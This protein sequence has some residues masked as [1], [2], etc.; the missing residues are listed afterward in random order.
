MRSIIETNPTRNFHALHQDG[1]FSIRQMA[2]IDDDPSQKTQWLKTF[3]QQSKTEFRAF[4]GQAYALLGVKS[5]YEIPALITQENKRNE[6]SRIAHVRLGKT[7][8]IEGTE[9]EIE[10]KIKS[11]ADMADGVISSLAERSGVLRSVRNRLEMANEVKAIDNPVDLLLIVFDT[12]WSPKARF[13]AARKLYLMK[14]FAS[15]DQRKRETRSSDKFNGFLE[16]LNTYVWSSGKKAETRGSTLLSVHNI[17]DMSCV[18]VKV[19]KNGEDIY[20]ETENDKQIIKRTPVQRRSFQVGKREI[21]AYVMLREQ[22]DPHL[23]ALKLLRKGHENPEIAVEDAVGLI[24]VVDNEHDV[25]L[26]LRHLQD[27]IAE[28]GSLCIL[29]DIKNKLADT[30]HETDGPYS[31]PQLR[32]FQ[33]F[34][35]VGGMRIELVLHT[36]E[37]YVEY[38]YRDGVSHDEYEV[39]RVIETGVADLLF[40]NDFFKID[41]AKQQQRIIQN[42]RRDMRETTGSD[43]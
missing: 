10:T 20:L 21:P 38:L 33:C 17:D 7:Y 37:T 3:N 32:Q 36:N 14:L 40:P 13:E 4:M 34:L 1:I 24:V 42:I 31:S 2:L 25:N 5:A 29:E 22:K 11:F 16:T 43:G 9:R 30:P 41:F 26:F 28:S 39:K 8:G 6:A 27:K 15:I 23:Q 18:S 19:A 35:R 12:T